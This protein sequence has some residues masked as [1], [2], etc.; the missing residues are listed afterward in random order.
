MELM[1]AVAAFALVPPPAPAIASEV[2][3]LTTLWSTALGAFVGAAAA[4]IIEWIRRAAEEKRRRIAASHVELLTLGSRWYTL[5]KHD[6]QGMRK[7]IDGPD[8]GI[9]LWLGIPP[10][11]TMAESALYS[12]DIAGLTFLLSSIDP[13]VWADLVLQQERY[14]TFVSNLK[15]R[16]AAVSRARE[17]MEAAGVGLTLLDPTDQ[18]LLDIIGVRGVSELRMLTKGMIEALYQ[19]MVDMREVHERLTVALRGTLGK[20]NIRPGPLPDFAADLKPTWQIWV[21]QAVQRCMSRP[22]GGVP[23]SR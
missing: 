6:T 9:P 21:K 4:F 2:S 19:T 23:A 8:A 3:W 12:F 20:K 10:A 1:G 15:E 13:Q 17:R 5:L 16:D 22:P 14:S 7:R 18:Q 11:L